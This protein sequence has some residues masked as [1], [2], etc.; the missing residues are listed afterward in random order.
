VYDRQYDKQT[1]TF[2][3]SGGLIN[4]S[5]V[6]QDRETDTY[7]PIMRGVGAEGQLKGVRL[8]ELAINKKMKWKKWRRKH[9]DTL[10]LSVNGHE[11]QPETYRNYFSSSQGFRGAQAKDDRLKTKDSVFVFRLREKEFA[12]PHDGL[13]GGKTFQIGNQQI[14][15]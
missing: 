9:P 8:K 6:M 4:S 14:F 1:L 7:W 13:V 12:I 2:E 10:V 3:A 5:L 15:L 11:D